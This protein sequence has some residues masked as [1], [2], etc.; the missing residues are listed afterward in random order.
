MEG[1]ERENLLMHHLH[2]VAS[3]AKRQRVDEG[4]DGIDEPRRTVPRP[5]KFRGRVLEALDFCERRAG[6]EPW[7]VR[8]AQSSR[9]AWAHGFLS[10]LASFGYNINILLPTIFEPLPEEIH[11]GLRTIFTSVG[12]LSQV[13]QQQ[14][15]D[16]RLLDWSEPNPEE[17]ALQEKA[18]WQLLD[19]VYEKKGQLSCVR[20]GYDPVS[21]QRKRISFNAATCHLTQMHPEE[22][23]AR[24]SS[25]TMGM[26]MTEF[27]FLLMILD[28][29]ANAKQS[30]ITRYCRLRFSASKFAFVRYD[31]MRCFDMRGR[32]VRQEHFLT[33][34]SSKQL[35]DALNS[36]P[37]QCLIVQMTRPGQRM[38]AQSLMTSF[39]SDRTEGSI[40]RM[41]QTVGG[42]LKCVCVCLCQCVCA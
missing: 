28:D 2:M 33:P 12:V 18:S 31:K 34:I 13:A 17:Q 42:R 20:V 35:D 40:S 10:R 41:C 26:Y 29:V 25:H 23:A 36:R 22:L 27:E 4:D 15:E 5:I 8:L 39:D 30:S 6:P 21:A 14:Q 37:K 7:E 32:M 19:E 38:S 11:H 1:S 16:W 24:M 9:L 3:T